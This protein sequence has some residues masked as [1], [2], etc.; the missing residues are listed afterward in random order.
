M[1]ASSISGSG[2]K[3]LNYFPDE[4]AEAHRELRSI[5]KN[6]QEYKPERKAPPP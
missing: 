5:R 6:E 4:E 3:L 2:P 1:N